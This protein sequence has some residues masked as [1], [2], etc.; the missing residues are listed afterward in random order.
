VIL[1]FDN[2]DSFTYTLA[3]YLA[4]LGVNSMIFRNNSSLAQITNYDYRGIVISPGPGIPK[5]SGVLMELIEFYK[6]KLP[7]LGICLG[8]QALGEYFGC[9]LVKAKKPMHG[10]VSKLNFN[11]IP[12]FRGLKQGSDFVRYNSLVLESPPANIRV[13][14]KSPEEE[15]MAIQHDNLPIT[16]I[17]F[18]PEAYL[19]Y[20][21]I[22]ILRNWIYI[23][24]NSEISLTKKTPNECN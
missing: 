20:K 7:M 22:E 9:K 17:Q 12:L 6:S 3:D 15:I 23:N 8:H 4:Q 21:G 24:I 14:A 10:K 16:G 2:F 18:H 11:D 19:T 1:L 13:I 5:N